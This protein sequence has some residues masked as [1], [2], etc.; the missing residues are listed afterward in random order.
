MVGMKIKK[1]IGVAGAIAVVPLVLGMSASPASAMPKSC[2]TMH[3]AYEQ[4]TLA[5]S[6]ANEM[7]TSFEDNVQDYVDADGY[8][9]RKGWLVDL[10]GRI[11]FYVGMDP[12]EWHLMD[13]ENI[14]RAEWAQADADAAYDAWVSDCGW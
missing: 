5:S 12:W 2:L 14:E 4:A 7:M 10:Q 13:A 8:Y 3:I 6:H 11:H 1:S 9:M